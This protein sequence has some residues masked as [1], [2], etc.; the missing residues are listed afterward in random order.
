MILLDPRAKV[1]IG[2]RGNRAHAPENTL[3]SLREAVALGADAVEFDL[4]VSRDGVL[5]LMHDATLDRTTN[6]SG[7]VALK[8][9]AE[10]K[11][12]D[13]G[14][15]FT[16]DGGHTFPW[17]GRGATVSTFDEVVE[18]LP[19]DLPCII[20]LK[21]PAS[22]EPVKLAIRRHGI[23][24]RVIVASLD[25]IAT[26]PLRREGFA[27]GACTP[28]VVNLVLPALFRRR[29]GPQPFQ[30]LCI[31]PRWHGV[32][33]PVAALVRAVRG[34]GIVIHVWTINDPACALR[35]WGQGVQG[36]VTD[37]PGSMLAALKS[38]GIDRAFPAN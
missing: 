37:D 31:P 32:S 28:D 5:V 12:L 4:R 13:A 27:L 8:S 38:A 23:S 36:I 1:V 7:S 17:R 19:R 21:T 18:S 30:A 20:E 26:R 22:T 14:S 15:R 9:I 10:L 11:E 24:H 33:V 2:H 6:G 25:R 16:R 29:I 34:S 3:E 35:L